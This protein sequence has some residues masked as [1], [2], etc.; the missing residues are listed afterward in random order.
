MNIT[1]D[2]IINQIC[3]KITANKNNILS[4]YHSSK[5][6]IGYFFIDDLLPN[7][8]AKACFSV[9]P[10]KNDMRCLK[11]IREHKYVSAQM[12][13]HNPLLEKVIYAFQDDK[14]VKLIGDICGIET[15]YADQSLYAGGLSLMANHN[16]LNPHLDNSHDA[17]RERWRV[18]NLLYYVTPNWELKNGGH[19]EL[20]PNGPKKNPIV[21]ESK[22]NRLVVM[23]TH[24]GS[25]HSVNKVNSELEARCCISN[26]YFSPLPLKETDKFHVTKYRGRPEETLKNIILDADAKLRMLLRKVFKKGIRKNP[27]IY[28][29]KEE[30]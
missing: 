8:L 27:H 2:E 12:N 26:Y 3:H 10:D 25:W 24:D 15:L 9:F 23:A 18:L 13:N 29:N 28:K 1:S 4:T 21:I 14:V 11:T 19:L 6:N 17:K 22:F 5:S 7:D 30:S 20:W 16:F